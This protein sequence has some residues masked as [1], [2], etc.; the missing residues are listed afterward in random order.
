GAATGR[1]GL[2]RHDFLASWHALSR[3]GPARPAHEA[4]DPRRTDGGSL[5]A[6]LKGPPTFTAQPSDPVNF[7]RDRANLR[8]S[9]V[10]CV[11][12]HTAGAAIER[13]NTAV[14]HRLRC[15]RSKGSAV[16]RDSTGD[17]GRSAGESR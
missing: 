13:R 3:V 16:A 1:N 2:V 8:D 6:A 14:V 17:R 9:S 15:R 10:L 11:P 12:V 5:I 7:I 4:A